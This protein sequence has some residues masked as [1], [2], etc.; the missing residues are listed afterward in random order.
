MTCTERSL[1]LRTGFRSA[2]PGNLFNNQQIRSINIEIQRL[3]LR[4]KG[5]VPILSLGRHDAEPESTPKSL[6]KLLPSK[7]REL[8]I[9]GLKFHIVRST[10]RPAIPAHTQSVAQAVTVPRGPVYIESRT[11]M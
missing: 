7:L 9:D 2:L 11:R 8:D 1:L 6:K 4:T 10:M 3:I 5:F